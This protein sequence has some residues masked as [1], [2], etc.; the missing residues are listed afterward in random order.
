MSPMAGKQNQTQTQKSS[1]L[2]RSNRATMGTD[3]LEHPFFRLQRIIGNQAVQRTLQM[4]RT[5]GRPGDASEREADDVAERVMRMPNAAE[6]GTLPAYE[7]IHTARQGAATEAGSIQRQAAPAVPRKTIWVNIGFDS[8]AQANEE[9]MRKLRSSIRV[10]K[11]AIASCCA[12]HNQACNIDVK[13]H[14]DWR[15]SNKPAPAD[16]DYDSDVAA[17][18]EL[19][20]RNFDNIAGRAGG[21][22]VLVTE[23][24][25]SQTWEGVRI[26]PRANTPEKGILWN[27]AL[28]AEDTLAHE[29]GHAAGYTG[30]AEGGHHST[31]PQNLMSSGSIREAGATPDANWCQQMAATA[32]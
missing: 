4:K 5:I 13:Q 2:A 3:H 12:V 16:G 15:R 24:T 8:S 14:Y 28:A 1:G 6:G 19:R 17:D 27:R 23:S 32:R 26:F 9:T 22:K 18:R 30:D 20:D 11:A 10:E 29:S 31:D 25:L 7:P 21:V